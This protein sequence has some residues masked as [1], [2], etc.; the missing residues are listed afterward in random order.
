MK[1]GSGNEVPRSIEM[2]Q[3]VQESSVADGIQAAVES[4]TKEAGPELE[5]M[6]DPGRNRYDKGQVAEH[7]LTGSLMAAQ[8]NS[9]LDAGKTGDPAPKAGSVKD[10]TWSELAW[11]PNV[12]PDK[13]LTNLMAK[14]ILVAWD[15]ITKK[16]E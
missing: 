12:A 11:D 14:G 6:K 16:T 8:L 7:G 1:I 5:N 10:K 13:K 3:T 9:Q 2:E 4:Q 15:A